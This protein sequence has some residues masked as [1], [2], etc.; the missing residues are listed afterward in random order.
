[1]SGRGPVRASTFVF[2]SV[3]VTMIE[4]FIGRN[5]SPVSIGLRPLVFWR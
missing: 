1:M 3:A 5:A 4:M 2:T